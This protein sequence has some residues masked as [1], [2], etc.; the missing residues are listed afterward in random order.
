MEKEKIFGEKI[1]TRE[2]LP[3][4]VVEIERPEAI[5]RIVYGYHNREQS[6]KDIDGLDVLILETG[7]SDYSN[8]EAAS[9]LLEACKKDVLYKSVV[10]KAEDEK[11]PIFFADLSNAEVKTILHDRIKNLEVTVGAV[12]A[13]VLLASLISSKEK[14][15]R[16]EFFEKSFFA[17]G[18]AYLSSHTFL[19]NI[20]QIS[21]D[22]ML[23]EKTASRHIARILGDLQEKIHPE[24]ESLIITLRNQLM[25]QKMIT[26][27][28]MLD[29]QD[30]KIKVGIVVGA[31]HHGIE[32][33]LQI[34]DAKRIKIIND[35][36]NAPEL[37]KARK[38][39]SIIARMDFSEKSGKWITT[40]I[41]HDSTIVSPV[42]TAYLSPKVE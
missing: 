1:Y 14:I 28:K 29:L 36:L 24:T 26:I 7:D 15:S 10:K 41:Y 25:A 2:K 18:S 42:D 11:M 9:N 8:C 19:D 38:T 20:Y 32:K 3:A 5:Y 37:E 35:L 17:L 40:G 21:R 6:A 4:N 27:T 31:R 13:L 12:T 23:D 39:A 16:R 22:S 33:A 30:S 34:K